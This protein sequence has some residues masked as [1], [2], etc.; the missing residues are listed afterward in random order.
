[1]S[2]LNVP[3]TNQIKHSKTALNFTPCGDTWLEA[4]FVLWSQWREDP[5]ELSSENEYQVKAKKER[6]VTTIKD[7]VNKELVSCGKRTQHN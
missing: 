3:F 1:M 2:V 4:F 5:V 7:G 6:K